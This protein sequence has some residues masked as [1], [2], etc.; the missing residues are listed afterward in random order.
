[1]LVTI[2]QLYSCINQ[3]VETG[4]RRHHH[5]RESNGGSSFGS[6]GPSD[7]LD[8]LEISRQHRGES[9]EP[10]YVAFQG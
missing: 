8:N 1:M 2:T 10:L 3:I 4:D 9:G 7:T 6:G 5:P